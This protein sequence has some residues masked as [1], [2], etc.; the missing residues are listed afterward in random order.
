MY[1]KRLAI[2]L[3]FLL[4]LSALIAAE[5]K[6]RIRTVID[7]ITEDWGNGRTSSD[8]CIWRGTSPFCNGGCDVLGHV[9]REISSSGDGE[10]CWTGIKVLCCPAAS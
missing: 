7:E 3:V 1:F 5:D 6:S 2:S 10:Q 9:V 8:G 4:S